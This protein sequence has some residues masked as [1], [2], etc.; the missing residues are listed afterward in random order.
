MMYELQI[1]ELF[2]LKLYFRFFRI[3]YQKIQILI[4]VI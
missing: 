1:I 4:G 3:R 2:T